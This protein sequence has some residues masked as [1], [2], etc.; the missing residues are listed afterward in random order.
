M[1]R[2]VNKVIKKISNPTPQDILGV[3]LSVFLVAAAYF[4]LSR[5]VDYL[6]VTIRLFD[7]DGPEYAIGSNR[8][9]PWYV[10]QI[11]VG[12]KQKT[13]QGIVLAE[14]IDVYQYPGPSVYNDAYVTLRLRTAKNR[15]T[16]QHIYEGSPLLIHDIR[17]FKIQDLLI[18][19]EI[20]DVVEKNRQLHKFSVLLELVPQGVGSWNFDNNSSALI[21]G[22]RKYIAD[23]LKSGMMIKDSRD[24]VLVKVQ[25]VKK[26]PGERSVVGAGGYV[27]VADPD[28]TQVILNLDIWAEEINGSYYYRK[29]SPLII[30]QRLHLI[31]DELSILGAIISIEPSL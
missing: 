25:D 21:K 12:K 24:N 30:D 28:R 20:V 5:Q 1:K 8:P 17:S 9:R 29:E 15:I 11:K 18:S 4:F 6:N 7:Y 31:F 23:V 19:G 3:F 2:V 26:Q 13:G 16:K 22:V 14:V 10:E 27:S